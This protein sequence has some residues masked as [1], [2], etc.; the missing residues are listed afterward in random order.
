[1]KKL[2]QILDNT[3]ILYSRDVVRNFGVHSLFRFYIERHPLRQN[4][5]MSVTTL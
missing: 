3:A 2:A 4:R 5:Q 1:M